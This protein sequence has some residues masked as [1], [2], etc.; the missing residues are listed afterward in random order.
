MD[1]DD[2]PVLTEQELFEYLH[3]DR[4]VTGVTRRQIHYAVMNREIKPSRLGNGNYFS[5]SDAHE[6]LASRKQDQPSRFTGINA[7][8][9]TDSVA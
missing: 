8:R 4:G 6:W 3:F 7:G 2:L 5:R 9:S 1:D